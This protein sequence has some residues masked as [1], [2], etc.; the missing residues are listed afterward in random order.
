M[1][2]SWSFLDKRNAT[3]E[4]VRAYNNMKFIVNH[5]GEEIKKVRQNRLFQT[6]IQFVCSEALVEA[7]NYS[8]ITHA[9]AFHS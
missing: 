9:T 5:T 2:I 4:A 8:A 7:R 6:K 3:K 1:H